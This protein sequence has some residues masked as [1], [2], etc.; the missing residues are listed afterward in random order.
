MKQ[1]DNTIHLWHPSDHTEKQRLVELLAI[2]HRNGR[3]YRAVIR[4]MDKP[5]RGVAIVPLHEL[6]MVRNV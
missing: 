1:M 6:R 2:Y 3:F 4:E 5:L